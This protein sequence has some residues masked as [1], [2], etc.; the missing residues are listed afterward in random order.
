[1]GADGDRWVTG[2]GLM[3]MGGVALP[4]GT[5]AAMAPALRL[6][7]SLGH[8]CGAVCPRWAWALLPAAQG[9]GLPPHGATTGCSCGALLPTC[10]APGPHRLSQP[11]LCMFYLQQLLR[12]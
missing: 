2:L 5:G 8:A 11:V 6:N 1:M 7:P 10:P 4:L 3:E 12:G 9:P